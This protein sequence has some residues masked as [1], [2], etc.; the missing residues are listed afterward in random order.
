MNQIP[1][2]AFSR[3]KD[4]TLSATTRALEDARRVAPVDNARAAASWS[5]PR[6]ASGDLAQEIK[7]LRR[8]RGATSSRTLVRD[9]PGTSSRLVSST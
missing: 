1:K 8:D 2:V 3:T 7:R 4:P 5:Q 9:S 6:I